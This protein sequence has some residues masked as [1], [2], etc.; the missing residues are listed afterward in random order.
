MAIRTV[1]HATYEDYLDAE[2]P[3]TVSGA[4]AARERDKEERDTRLKVFPHSVVLQLSYPELDYANR[5]C[6]QQFGP[7]HGQCLQAQSDYPACF[8][9]P[10][11]SHDG[12]WMSHWLVKTAYNF[13]FNE[14][15][16]ARQADLNRFL[17]FVPEINW[18]DLYPKKSP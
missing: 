18:G 11:H 16:F 5:W 17:D 8:D 3:M 7:S 12:K 10:P 4:A 9:E 13:G 14:W 6:W 15:C 2:Y 1:E